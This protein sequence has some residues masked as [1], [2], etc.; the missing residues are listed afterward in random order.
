MLTA[1]QIKLLEEWCKTNPEAAKEP[2]IN[3]TTG[4]ELTLAGALEMAQASLAGTVQLDK[5]LELSIDDIAQWLEGGLS[6][7]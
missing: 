7:G 3:P 6:D 5:T 1:D 4:Q 2:F